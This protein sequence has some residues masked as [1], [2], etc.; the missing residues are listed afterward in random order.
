MRERSRLPNRVTGAFVLQRAQ[1]HLHHMLHGLVMEIMDTRRLELEVDP[2]KYRGNILQTQR[3][4]ESYADKFMTTIFTKE[5]ARLFPRPVRALSHHVAKLAIDLGIPERKYQFVGNLIVLRFITP[6]IA[7]PD[8]Y[9]VCTAGRAPTTRARRNLI[10]LSKLVQAVANESKF[11]DKEKFMVPFNVFIDRHSERMRIFLDTLITLDESEEVSTTGA[12]GESKPSIDKEKGEK[13]EKE[14][15]KPLEEIVKE[16]T[17]SEEKK[18]K[19]EEAKEEGETKQEKLEGKGERKGEGEA[20]SS[21]YMK[22]EEPFEAKR[23][24]L[25]LEDVDITQYKLREL[26]I[27][28]RVLNKYLTTIISKLPKVAP[29]KE[30]ERESMN[31][32]QL[33]HTLPVV[34]FIGPEPWVDIREP[35]LKEYEVVKVNS[36]GKKQTRIIKF[37]GVSLLNIHR[38]TPTSE[39]CTIKN[40]LL[41]PEIHEIEAKPDQ[42]ILKLYFSDMSGKIPPSPGYFPSSEKA[43]LSFPRIYECPN[44]HIRDEVLGEVFEMCFSSF[45]ITSTGLNNVFEVVKV[46]KTGKHQNRVYKLS[47]D[48]LMNCSG[49]SVKKEYHF[50]TLEYARID[51]KDK[52]C[53]WLKV[54]REDDVR[55]HFFMSDESA[56]EFVKQIN[57]GIQKFER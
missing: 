10:L 13:G 44:S 21:K 47:K 26:A 40:E 33:V 22:K 1:P 46:N 18:E 27:A 19:E 45:N 16:V 25:A 9:G 31:L 37:T 41:V 32:T 36:R 20:E 29:P 39:S 7:I 56:H 57:D 8:F 28:H 2:D 38:K 53:V 51:E 12:D 11:G 3:R 35:R 30:A 23:Q 42:N 24:H 55:Q 52:K 48:S 34:P 54:K 17:I 14:E 49:S 5:N 50:A 4:L 6:A 15:K 43:D